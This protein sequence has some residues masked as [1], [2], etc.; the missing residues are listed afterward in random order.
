MTLVIFFSLYALLQGYVAHWVVRGAALGRTGGRVMLLWAMLMSAGPL[1]AWHAERCEGCVLWATVIVW[2]VYGWMGFSFLFF[3]AG[4][5]LDTYDGVARLAHLPR[6]E[7]ATG[8]LWLALVTSAL[9]LWGFSNAWTPRI[10]RV[11]VT[12]DKL[13]PHAAGLRIVQISDVHLGS[14]VGRGRL[15]A[16]LAAVNALKPDMLVST[17]D[18]MD[19]AG[20]RVDAL[21]PMLAEVRPRYGK[22][23]VM[24][25]HEA[26]LGLGRAE[27]FHARAGFRLLRDTRVDVAG[28]VVAGFDD[29]AVAG[30]GWGAIEA[31]RGL[32]NE[33]SPDRFVV[34]LKHRPDIEQGA[35]FDL[36]LSGHTHGGQIF[37]F[38]LLIRPIFPWLSG[39]HVV[40]GH[41]Q[42]YI[43][44]GTGTWGPPLRLFADPEV[45]L[46]ELR[47]R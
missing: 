40:K 39:L 25:N 13:P 15:A 20:P 16:I 19:A 21:A 26:Y 30:Q 2:L 1:L 10:E 18:L 6:L 4:L 44:R 41:A 9:W 22:Y 47:R 36:Q 34:V 37:P 11:V 38:G 24:G 28:I 17:G 43:S 46:I 33:V 29:P 5:V 23:A 3:C 8:L 14:L 35:A 42:L 12:T 45:T 27:A 31:E 32:L 7:T